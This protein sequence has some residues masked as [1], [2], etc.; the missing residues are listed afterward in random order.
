[1]TE[2]WCYLVPAEN[3]RT[4]PSSVASR[5]MVHWSQNLRTADDQFHYYD[6]GN[7]CNSTGIAQEMSFL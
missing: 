6:F 4:W 7:A 2:A 5:N 1:M 3:V